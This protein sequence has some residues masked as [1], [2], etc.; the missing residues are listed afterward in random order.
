MQ[1]LQIPVLAWLLLLAAVAAIYWPSLA[2]AFLFDDF[3]NIVDNPAVHLTQFSLAGLVASLDGLSAG[4]L[5]RPVSVWSFALTHLF[6]GLDPFAFKATNLILHLLNGVLVG[7]FVAL[8]L[9]V[10]P[11]Q[12]GDRVRTWLPLW[13]AGAWLLHPIHFVALHMAVQRMTLLAGGFTLLA[14]IVHLHATGVAQSTPRRAWS[15]AAWG[16][17]WPIAFLSKENGLL[18]P[19]FVMLIAWLSGTAGHRVARR[20]TL[21]ASGAALALVGVAMYWR[22]GWSWLEAGYAVRDFTLWERL[23]TQSRVLWFHLGQILTPTHASFSIYLDW[24]P[25]SHGL[26]DP[27]GTLF[28]L[29][30]WGL[31]VVLGLRYRRRFPILCFGIGWFLVGHG[32]ESSFVPLE[33]AHEHRNYLPALGP[34][35]AV[36]WYGVRLADYLDPARRALLLSVAALAALVLL[37]VLTGLRSV[38]MG[39][40]LLGAQIEAVRH[41]TSAR[42]NYEAGWA[43]VKAGFGDRDDPMGGTNVRFFF[44]QAERSDRS[45][46]LG[47]LSLIT[48]ACASERT[49]EREW[50]DDFADR[51]EG[52][53]FSH[54][55]RRLPAFLLRPLVAMPTCLTRGDALRLFTAGGRNVRLRPRVRAAFFDAAADYA[56]LVA[57]DPVAARDQLSRASDLDPGNIHLKDKLKGLELAR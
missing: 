23:L 42:A 14:L 6:F 2:G 13:V 41:E 1:K 34:L 44:E 43:L 45:F 15:I 47:Y 46:K 10:L 31:V 56:L 49:V 16:V 35:L 25:V 21:V 12:A 17:F 40:P 32:M 33:I 51:L 24:F 29:V 20:T 39:N 28:A 5:G 55:Q 4:P 54:G 26:I 18:F 27:P 36:G 11:C 53:P 3:S 57:H 50:L 19:L 37:A 8:L 48:W 7:W 22:I 38:Q 52:T 9:K 30:A